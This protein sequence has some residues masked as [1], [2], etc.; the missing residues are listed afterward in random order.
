[1]PQPANNSVI[2]ALHNLHSFF[3]LRQKQHEALSDV[4]TETR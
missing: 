3:Q 2:P 1:L 4:V